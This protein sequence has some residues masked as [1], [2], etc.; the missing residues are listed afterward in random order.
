M[1]SP[2]LSSPKSSPSAEP[3]GAPELSAFLRG[4]IAESNYPR[5][6]LQLL[7]Q[8]PVGLIIADAPSG[9]VTYANTSV[10]RMLRHPMDML[11]TW[12]LFDGIQCFDAQD[13]PILPGNFPLAR[14]VL[15]EESVEDYLISIVFNRDDQ[16]HF[17]VNA[18]P[19]KAE[20]GEVCAAFCTFLDVT[21][22][23]EARADLL[24]SEARHHRATSMAKVGVWELDFA[25]G[26][27]YVSP[28][29]KAILGY[30]DHEIPNTLEAWTSLVH[31]DEVAPATAA[32]N[33][34]LKRTVADYEMEVRRRHKDGTYRWLLSRGTVVRDEN[35]DATGLVG[36]DTDITELKRAESSLRESED[37]LRLGLEA[38]H[39][40]TWDWDIPG[41]CISWSTRTFEIH[42]I[43]PED[44]TGRLDQY[45]P[46][47]HPDDRQ[48][49]TLAVGES[50][51]KGKTYE[52]LY[53][54]VR[55]SGEIRWVSTVGKP[56]YDDDGRPVRLLGA[57]SDVTERVRLD[58]EREALLEGERAARAEIERAS[59]LKDEFLATLSH[60]LRT[61]LNSIMGWA[62][63]LQRD[64]LDLELRTEGLQS[65]ERNARSQAQIIEDLLDMSRILAGKLRLRIQP[66]EITQVLEA[67]VESVRAVSEAR[68]IQILVEAEPLP[69]SLWADSSRLHQILWNLL[70]NAVKF[71]PPGGQVT[72]KVHLLQ[73]QPTSD[74]PGSSVCFTV[75]D[76]GEGIPAEFLPY[77][78]DR[79]RQADAST[80]RRH[81]GLGLGLSIVKH[82]VE[83]HGG[84]I[85][86]ASEG[87]G[88]GA[89]FSFCLPLN[90]ADVHLR[91]IVRALPLVAPASAEHSR[92]VPE[93]ISS[94]LK[95]V[96]VLVVED[97]RDLRDLIGGLL[98]L[99]G[100][101]VHLTASVAEAREALVEKPV[102]VLI[103]DLSMPGED[104]FS[105]M[106]AWRRQ[107]S[108]TRLP[109]I[110]L[111][112]LSRLQ[113]RDRALEAGFDVHLAKPVEPAA[114]VAVV[115]R[116][117]KGSG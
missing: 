114:L 90:Y 28:S 57:S 5:V 101:E 115:V 91:D 110:A 117:L 50:L 93:E 79:F 17:R 36:S 53:R 98:G 58:T 29:L 60:E 21:S 1:E 4:W 10:E 6:L 43:N 65:I 104:G 99:A 22:E 83:L 12:E 71:S 64:N 47:I 30:A 18:T 92:A 86:A 37:R 97:E 7:E 61:P 49:A 73:G 27:L 69:H 39:A 2:F 95:G 48:M 9:R 63:L 105:F 55:P 14:A 45:L 32:F 62:S 59:R 109:A 52:I 42:G 108:G 102:D 76:R 75:A 88:K 113:D 89:K 13:L 16:R 26:A 96:R 80:T 44:W 3:P 56:F 100:A 68:H 111:S 41:D 81:G 87:P 74:S 46:L 106:R 112:A 94:P 31:P 51:E 8:L 34:H 54:I 103:S 84:E 40:G 19:I 77:A 38:A 35:G 85:T 116:L 23:I 11:G 66:V 24:Q 33:A 67:A 15:K 82:L 72:L 20:S 107:E 78:F 25:S 70:T